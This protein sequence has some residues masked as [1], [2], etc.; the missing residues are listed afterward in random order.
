[1]ISRWKGKARA[2][3]DR[4]QPERL[5]KHCFAAGVGTGQK[6]RLCRVIEVDIVS[7]DLFGF[8]RPPQKRMCGLPE[9]EALVLLNKD[10]LSRE[11]GS[12]ARARLHD[13]PMNE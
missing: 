9:K 2:R 12:E 11:T 7:Y 1:M 4:S 8:E 10:R 13:V 6:Q 3:A 5:Q